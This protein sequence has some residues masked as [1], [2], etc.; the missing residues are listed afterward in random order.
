VREHREQLRVVW[1]G[2]PAKWEGDAEQEQQDRYQQR[3]GHPAG[4]EQ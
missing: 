4:T 1:R 3:G 2:E